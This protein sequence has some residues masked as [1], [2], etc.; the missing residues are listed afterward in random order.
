MSIHH[1]EFLEQAKKVPV[2]QK[3]RVYHGAEPTRAMDVFNNDDS[4]S[5][6]CHRCHEAGY[7]R[8]QYVEEV[9]E[10]QPQF[11][12]YLSTSD[13]I[14]LSELYKLDKH[15]YN[16]LVLLLHDKGMSS[17]TIESL[18][19]MYNTK[20][21]R[22]VFKFKG[23][24]IGR[25]CTGLSPMKWF[26]YHL[27]NPSGY[28]YLQGKNSFCNKE[29]VILT[30]DLF[31]AQKIRYYTGCSTMPLFGTSLKDDALV[32]L[33]DKFPVLCLD[34]D[35]GGWKATADITNKL[36]LYSIAH[37]IL[38]VPDDNDPKDLKPSELIQL[39]KGINYD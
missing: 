18:K 28:V 31:S 29:P 4:W 23:I 7:V 34:G 25:D 1:S 21:D 17:V 24:H 37:S 2:G 39:V 10:V 11:R 13:C 8:K 22:L 15:K 5:C 27:D 20:D 33:S 36:N 16:R 26:K 32:H 14:S 9:T 35:L 38:K 6:Y 3:R 12:K 30:E 19:P